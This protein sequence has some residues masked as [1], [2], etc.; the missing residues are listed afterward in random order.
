MMVS[1]SSALG[2]FGAEQSFGA[3]KWLPVVGF[4]GVYEVSDYGR[5][6]RVLPG[7][8]A[9]V[10]IRKPTTHPNGYQ[11]VAL[12][13]RNKQTARKV[14][15]LVLEAFVGPCP[16]GMEACHNDDNPFNNH[17]RNLRWDT[18]QS[19]CADRSEIGKTRKVPAL[20]AA[21]RLGHN[22]P[23]RPRRDSRG[24]R[25]CETCADERNRRARKFPRDEFECRRGHR[26]DGENLYVS[27]KGRR[28][29]RACR[30][31]S[32]DR[33]DMDK[34]RA[35]DRARYHRS[36]GHRHGGKTI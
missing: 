31:L 35:S 5:V 34:R 29:C 10:G 17:L 7:Q 3:E 25:V 4:E 13:Y 23:E 14:H 6:R 19:N 2:R 15:R 30:R 33:R 12:S 21:C 22:Y 27:P 24:N 16:D 9:T 20:R 28:G 11:I 26:L 8:G 18:H 32:E 36:R 1:E